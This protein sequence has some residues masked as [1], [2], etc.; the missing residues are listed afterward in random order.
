MFTAHTSDIIFCKVHDTK[1]I[2]QPMPQPPLHYRH[3]LTLQSSPDKLWE[4]L[5][6]TD[7]LNHDIGLSPISRV[8]EGDLVNNR[9]T[10]QQ[11]VRGL[12][13]Q[14]WTE[15]PF[16]WVKPYHY[17]T[18]RNYSRG[19]FDTIRQQLDMTPLAAG[20]TDID[21]QVW[22]KPRYRL[23]RGLIDASFSNMDFPGVFRK[24]DEMIHNTTDLQFNAPFFESIE[25]D[26]VDG[27]R[28]RLENFQERLVKAGSEP[29]LAERLI[30]YLSHADDL[31]AMTI[32][33]YELAD[34]WNNARRD[35][36]DTCLIAT[37]IGMLDMRWDLL[38]PL[39]RGAKAT[40]DKLEDITQTTHC[41]VC[42]I[43]YT[44]NFE[45]SVELTFKPSAQIREIKTEEYCVGGPEVTPHIEIQQLLQPGETREVTPRLPSGRYR[46]RTMTLDGG[47]YFR[48]RPGM[49]DR[50]SFRASSMD[51]WH[52]GEPNIRPD[53][54]ITLVNATD[55][56][57]LFV[58]EHL[59]WSDQS[60][61][62]ADVTTRQ[63]FRDL[64]ASEALRPKE[65]IEI[66]SLTFVFTDLR[67]STQ[68][69]RDVGDAPAF[70]L[71]MDHFDILRERIKQEDGAIVKTIGDAVMAVFRQP[72]KAVRA[73]LAAHA[74]LAKP[75][76]VGRVLNLRVGIHT[77]K[78]IAVTLNERL[79]YFGTTVNIAP[80][81]EGQ[82]DGTNIVVSDE[83]YND[84]NVQQLLGGITREVDVRSYETELK[85]FTDQAFTLWQIQ[86]KDTL[87]TQDI[88]SVHRASSDEQTA[89]PAN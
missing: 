46:I 76:S 86:P 14:Q 33:P 26:F 49:D 20:G 17:H 79:E 50:V 31:S 8:D 56:E 73:M 45:Q 58:V 55:D 36:L 23:V 34:M 59:V 63:V 16:E 66:N 6:D 5:A 80:R 28:E 52:M 82:A 54:E 37:R 35:V 38:C 18:L 68:M 40:V 9:K 25:I 70:G 44:A 47:Q 87:S 72:E 48:V 60:V 15:E 64:F 67:S 13:V 21:Y 65:Q 88:P 39:C 74:E 3:Q 62:A 42:R 24:Y 27:G 53:A 22:V 84:P 10:V 75:E 61:T 41:E 81:V 30:R 4:Y 89:P 43:D 29:V 77:G 1:A 57:Q 7:R 83:V 2:F 51:G 32:R 11:T 71:V 78:S 12:F 19:F 69:Y 85:G